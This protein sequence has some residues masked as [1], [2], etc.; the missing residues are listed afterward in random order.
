MRIHES[1]R[2][3]GGNGSRKCAQVR[4]DVTGGS[5][6]EGRSPRFRARVSDDLVTDV[7][8]EDIVVLVEDINGV[9]VLVEKVRCP[10]GIQPVD[11][12]SARKREVN[13]ER[14]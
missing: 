2:C 3:P 12:A 11:G 9:D 10:C 14:R 1:V 13:A 4:P 7:I 5:F 8:R 6:Y